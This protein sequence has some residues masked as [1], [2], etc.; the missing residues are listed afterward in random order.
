MEGDQGREAEAA[1]RHRNEE[2]ATVCLGWRL[3]ELAKAGTDEWVRTFAIITTN[4][5]ELVRTI[6]DRMPV[7]IA[8]EDYDRWLSPLDPDTRALLVPFPSEPMTMWPISTR[9]NKP[10]NDDASVLERVNE[11]VGIIAK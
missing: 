6:H 1:L 5:N 8:P 2:R 3:G 11:P 9:V 4:A 10:E 7:I